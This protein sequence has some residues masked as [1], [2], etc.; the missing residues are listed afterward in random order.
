MKR[1]ILLAFLVTF[2]FCSDAQTKK[3]SKTLSTEHLK[4]HTSYFTIENGGFK[5]KGTKAIKD[6]V[7]SS[8]FITYGEIHGSYQV[9]AITK[10]F[11]PLLKKAGFNHFAIEVGPTSAKK[12]TELSTPAEKTVENLKA[13]NSKY[14]VSKG[15]ESAHP[16]P[17]FDA[18][19]DAEFLQEARANG[20]QLWG[21][22]QEYYYATFFLVDELMRTVEGTSEAS[23]LTS[24]KNTAIQIMYKH[25][26]DEVAEKI[27]DAY[28]LIVKEKAVNDFFDA[29]PKDNK[30]AQEIINNMK[31]SWDIY[32]RWRNDSHVDRISYIRNNFMK[33]YNEALAKEKKP[34]VFTK[35][36]SL[37]ASKILS[38]TAFDVGNLTEELAQRNKTQST[39][40]TTWIPFKQTEKGLV[41]NF[42][43][44]KRS[45]ARYSMITPLAQKDQWAIVNLKEIR[46]QII[47]GKV[48]LP[49]NGDYHK[50]KR[51][52]WGYDYLIMPSVDQE[53]TPNRTN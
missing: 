15:K 9:S 46:E 5:G 11:M 53:N 38:N 25:F 4:K 12:L 8:Q 33:H 43:K 3:S 51:L 27:D 18:V 50:L 23:R 39:T 34:K 36:G 26:L 49:T 52:I 42:E 19:S 1:L 44:Y 13:F 14:T 45:Y 6:L 28:P 21:L 47:K 2:S 31:I 10:A 20:M 48:A 40:I 7:N 29:F 41:N 24:L 22:D 35:I 37:H 30:E 17:F 32:I 16:I